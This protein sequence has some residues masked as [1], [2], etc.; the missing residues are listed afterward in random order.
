MNAAAEKAGMKL[1]RA[2]SDGRFCL[3]SLDLA[4]ALE[5]RRYRKEHA[6][7]LPIPPRRLRALVGP[8]PRIES[9]LALGQRTAGDI[10]NA[11]AAVGRELESFANILDFGCGCGRQ[12]RWFANLP[13]S[14]RLYGSDVCVPAIRWNRRCLPFAEFKLNGFYPPLPYPAETFDLVYAL[15][16]FTHLDESNQSAWVEELR[17]VASPGALV[18]I[19]VQGEVGLAGFRDGSL[20]ASAEFLER[21]NR[22]AQLGQEG[23]IFEPYERGSKYGLAFHDDS[24]IRE[25]WGRKLRILKFIPRG[26]DGWQDV[27]VLEKEKR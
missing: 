14:C 4:E 8:D 16:V 5:R 19:T 25:H 24:Y 22:H 13:T 2:L 10:R 15:S 11:L 3:Q 21:L 26:G 27:V 12:M 6:V 9:F 7:A 20:P 23:L 18:I 17:R 1:K